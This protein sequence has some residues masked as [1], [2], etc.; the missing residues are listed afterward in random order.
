[1][2][3]LTQFLNTVSQDGKKS[4]K[5]YH[6]ALLAQMIYIISIISFLTI[7]INNFSCFLL[8]ILILNFILILKSDAD[9][10]LYVG[11]VCT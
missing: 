2:L 8:F 9:S 1:M 10:I 11:L 6:C 4:C 5:F 7:F 3:Y